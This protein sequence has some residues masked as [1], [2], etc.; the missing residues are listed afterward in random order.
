[1]LRNL[2]YMK[3]YKD[4]DT[5]FLSLSALLNVLY[6][7]IVLKHLKVFRY[8]RKN[9][10]V[11][12]RRNTMEKQCSGKHTRILFTS[13]NLLSPLALFNIFKKNLAVYHDY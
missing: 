2:Q 7:D 10:K 3:T 11:F 4:M 9:L 5:N 8:H 12:F 13:T 1:M 6:E